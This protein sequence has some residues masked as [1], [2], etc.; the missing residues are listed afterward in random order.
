MKAWK[1]SNES[2]DEGRVIIVFA[3][4]R[5]KAMSQGSE[6]E[7]GT[8][9]WTSLRAVRA[10]HFD[11]MENLTS[12]EL[13]REMWHEGW[14][15]SLGE[16]RLPIYDDPHYSLEHF[17]FLNKDDVEHNHLHDRVFDDWYNRTY[18]KELNT[19]R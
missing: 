15:F 16:E 13:M 5:G 3:E 19:F 7:L 14:W 11:D 9:E 1:L 12:K 8:F 6:D 4:N 10:K 18:D 2:D 17:K